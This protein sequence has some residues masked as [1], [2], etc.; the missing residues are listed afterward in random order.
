M[1]DLGTSSN[2]QPKIDT[3]KSR[4]IPTSVLAKFPGLQQTKKYFPILP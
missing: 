3:Y 1:D 2:I 4:D